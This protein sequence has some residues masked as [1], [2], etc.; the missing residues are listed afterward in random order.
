MAR[1][2]REGQKSHCR[3]NTMGDSHCH[4]QQCNQPTQGN[5]TYDIKKQLYVTLCFLLY[6][7]AAEYINSTKSCSLTLHCIRVA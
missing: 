2:E 3:G 1:G 5:L 4:M 6:T 7:Y